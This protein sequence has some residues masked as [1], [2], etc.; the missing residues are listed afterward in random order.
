M[1][2]LAAIL[3]K[4]LSLIFSYRFAFL[5]RFFGILFSVTLWYF[6]ARLVGEKQPDYYPF[7][8]LGMAAQTFL[9][10]HLYGTAS[11]LREEQLSG[12]LEAL[13]S[14]PTP[15]LTILVGGS[16]ADFLNALISFT[17]MLGA[18]WFVGPLHLQVAHPFT[19]FA[20]LLL[21][22]M[23]LAALAV[24]NAGWLG[25]SMVSAGILPA[26]TSAD[27]VFVAV[28][29]KVCV[30]GLFGFVMA[31]LTAALM[32]TVDTL[33]NAVA[34]VTVNDVYKPY[35][36]PRAPD[37]HYLKVAR[38]VSLSS[39]LVGIALREGFLESL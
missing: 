25:R 30:P 23:P 36:R 3:H 15:P 28:A 33:I 6:I 17:L 7:V 16:I 26:D 18:A 29:E 35:F 5:L 10:A 19:A 14:T 39:A 34:A 4:D 32:S 11:R 22:L 1:K 21:V 38:I 20:A 12:T 31:A 13:L 2:P 9:S 8:I 24:A 27:H 37:A